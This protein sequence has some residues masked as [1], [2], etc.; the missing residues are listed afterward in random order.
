MENQ[1]LAQRTGRSL[2]G[3]CQEALFFFAAS[4]CGWM[5]EVA[6]YWVQHPAYSLWSLIGHYRGVLHGPW[7]PIYG[8]GAVLMVWLHRRAG[9]HPGRFLLLCAGICGAV[10]YLTSWGLEQIFHARWW[11][12]TGYF[13]NLN[14]RIC[15]LSLL[16]F[17]LAG[18]AVSYWI[19]P[20]F[21][22]LLARV[23]PC[24]L[25]LAAGGLAALFLIDLFTALIHPNLGMGVRQL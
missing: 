9:T 8:T 16:V 17:A 2:P 24:W 23:P 12:Y 25:R 11:D 21:R 15:A 20:R 19:A 14:G 7:A 18:G 4:F 6:V 10:E 22:R 1:T 3:I 5:W 13:L